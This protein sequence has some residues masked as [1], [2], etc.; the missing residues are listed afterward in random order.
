MENLA[1]GLITGVVI[2]VMYLSHSAKKN[3]RK[4]KEKKDEFT[5]R[6]DDL[7]KSIGDDIKI[8]DDAFKQSDNES[9]I[10]DYSTD[11]EVVEKFKAKRVNKKINKDEEEII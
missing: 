11:D 2:F 1:I 9:I 10:D 8:K 7:S 4:E 6:M 5:K 3:E